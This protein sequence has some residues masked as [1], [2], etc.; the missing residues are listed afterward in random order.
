MRANLPGWVMIILAG[1]IYGAT[2]QFLPDDGAVMAAA[3]CLM[4]MDIGYRLYLDEGE[5]K[6]QQWFAPWTGGF[7]LFA[8][9][10]MLPI[11]VAA[12]MG[13]LYLSGAI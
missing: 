13:V 9:A 8:P 10:W 7:L 1:C 11:A 5:T 12:I 3:V 2:V 6:F 4:V